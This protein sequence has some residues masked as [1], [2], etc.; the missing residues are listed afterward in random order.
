MKNAKLKM[1]IGGPGYWP[2]AEANSA[3]KARQTEQWNCGA[4]D[5]LGWIPPFLCR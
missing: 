4:W 5:I 1:K 3:L 2:E